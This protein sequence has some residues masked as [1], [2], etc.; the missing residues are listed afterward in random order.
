M[1]FIKSKKDNCEEWATFRNELSDFFELF[2][3]GNLNFIDQK[4]FVEY[5]AKGS[6]QHFHTPITELNDLKFRLL[7]KVVNAWYFSGF[8][9][10]AFYAEKVKRFNRHD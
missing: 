4:N 8:G 5:L 9:F 1:Y 3:D 10:E 2:A 7:E 6:N